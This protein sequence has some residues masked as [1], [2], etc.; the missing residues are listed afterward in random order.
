MRV[1]TFRAPTIQEA[2]QLVRK[3]LGPEASVV[4]TRQVRKGMFARPMIEVQASRELV[5]PSRFQEAAIP[6]SE[7]MRETREGFSTQ[8][9]ETNEATP[10]GRTIPEPVYAE[11]AFTNTAATSEVYSELIQSGVPEQLS[12]ELLSDACRQCNDAFHND[13]WLIWGQ[14]VEVVAK[15]LAIASHAEH[16]ASEQR[17]L[18]FVGPP[19][20]GKTSML[21]KIAARA[22]IEDR[23]DIGIVA[24]DSWRSEAGDQLLGLADS[25]SAHVEAVSST[26][27]LAGALQRLRECD[28]VLID[29][30]GRSPS[31]ANQMQSLHEL[32]E[33]ALPD[34]VHLVLDANSAPAKIQVAVDRFSRLGATRLNITKL[35]E[36]VGTGQWLSCLISSHI[37]VQNLSHAADHTTGVIQPSPRYLASVLLGQRILNTGIIQSA[38]QL[39]G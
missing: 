11:P 37:P 3:N 2:L 18:A 34:E 8:A 24:V 4:S 38:S 5:V 20:A 27:Q 9:N 32:L 23:I 13:V 6:I 30:A 19:A 33:V 39:P 26:E 36:S 22:Y 17:M 29:T 14:I 1:L 12:K 25:I 28:L 31:D 21:C 7:P 16:D 35:D 10:A 15:R